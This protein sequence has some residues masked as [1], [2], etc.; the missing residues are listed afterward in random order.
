MY[1]FSTTIIVFHGG[2]L[3]FQLPPPPAPARRRVSRLK[4]ART[5]EYR[6]RNTFIVLR[7]IDTRFSLRLVERT[8][9]ARVRRDGR[10]SSSLFIYID[11]RNIYIRAIVLLRSSI[12]LQQRR[13]VIAGRRVRA[14]RGERDD[15]T[16]VLYLLI[17]RDGLYKHRIRAQKH[18]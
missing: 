17:N 12:A 11:S 4:F 13:C 2:T 6:I 5:S 14:R 16:R 9:I 15:R 18:Y 7:L 3:I 10:V 8:N 1:G